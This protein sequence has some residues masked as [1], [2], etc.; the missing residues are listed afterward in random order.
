MRLHRFA[1]VALA[2]TATAIPAAATAAPPTPHQL[3]ISAAPNPVVFGKTV[4]ITGKLTGSD[5][6]GETVTLRDDP[7]PFSNFGNPTSTTT[8]A[9]GTYAFTVAPTVNT[10][11]EAT[12]KSKAPA[13][14]PAL[15]VLVAPRVG[16][17]V[18]DLTPKVGQTVT[19]QGRVYPPH[20]GQN[21]LLQRHN[22]TGWHTLAT[23][24]L[25]HAT[26]TYSF[27]SHKRKVT[28]NGTFRVVKPKDAD[29]ARGTSP[30]RKLTVHN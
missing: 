18:S 17:V 23:I 8:K 12:A 5:S 16:L 14:S 19:F 25:V 11:Y 6:A 22:S 9:D 30:R 27:Y 4:A 21:V 10:K 29:H 26:D 7:F 24:P 15:T 20:D 1:V 13:T 3:S 28:R 2:A